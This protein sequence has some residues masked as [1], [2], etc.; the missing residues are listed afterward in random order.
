[1]PVAYQIDQG[2]KLIRT[3]CSGIVTIEEV[4]GHFRQLEHDPECPDRLDVLLDLSEQRTVPSAENLRAMIGEI[5]RIR[6]KVQFQ[7]C[8]IVACSDV[9]FG[10][11]RMF[12]VFAEDYFQRTRVFRDKN[13]AEEW[14][15]AQRPTVSIAR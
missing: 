15:S 2:R 7:W 4:I 9:L 8:A 10:M 11:L 6:M 5:S 1:M 12:E 13:E 14:L 3:T